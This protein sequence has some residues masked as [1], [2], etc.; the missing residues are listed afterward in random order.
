MYIVDI[1]DE[2]GTAVEDI[3]TFENVTVNN[4]P[5][6]PIIKTPLTNDIITFNKP[7]I[8]GIA[9]P[10]SNVNIYAD[11]VLDGNT[12]ADIDGNWSYNIN[13]SLSE[14]IP[15]VQTGI[16]IIQ[17]SFTD[18]SAP[19]S[20]ISITI[21]TSYS[22][23]E[24]ILYPRVQ[25][26]L[27]NNKPLLKG[28]AQKDTNIDISLDGVI[29][30]S[31]VADA[32]CKWEF[33]APL[34]PNGAH[35]LS[36]NAGI[37]TVNFNVDNAVAFPLITY[38]GS[39]LDGFLI[40]NNLPLIK[41]VALPGTPVTLWLNYIQY[42]T[43]GTVIADANGNWEFQVIP[44]TYPDPLSG[45]PIILAPIQN[46]VN[47]VS[48]SLVNHTV[49]IVVSGYKLN[50]PSYSSITGVVDNTVF[51]TLFSPK[52]MIEQ[53]N[54]LW[55]SI[56]KK[57]PLEF[58]Y[59]ETA[60]K[61]G[62]FR[63]VLGTKV[64]QENTDIPASSF[65]EPLLLLEEATI[66]TKTNQ[67]FAKALYNFNNGGV[68][69]ST[70]RGKDIFA[71]PIGSM[72]MSNIR[73][74]IQEWKLLLSPLTSY[75]TL[76]NLYRNGLIINLMKN[77]IY[78]SDYNSLHF[79]EYN[80]QLPE[81]FS[82]KEIYDDWFMNRNDAWADS[83]NYIQKFKKID[84]IRD[85]VITNG[86]SN[87]SL[88]MCRCRDGFPIH[89]YAYNPI[90][91]AP[92]SIPE[93]VLETP[94]IDFDEY[95]EDQY[96]FLLMCGDLICAVSERVETRRNWIIGKART[97]LIEANK[98]VNDV[99]FF[100]STGIR[101]I[102][103]VEG[104]IKKW[105][106]DINTIVAQ[107]ESG[108]TDI[109]WSQ[110]SR[111]RIVRYG[112]AKGLPDYLAMKIALAIVLDNLQIEGQDM[113]I[114]NDDKIIPSEDIEGVPLYYYNVSMTAKENTKGK[115]FAGD[116]DSDV[117]GAVLNIDGTAIGMPVGSLV[118]IELTNQ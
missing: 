20:T 18:L 112:T 37:D 94:D 2:L 89:T 111:K 47:V 70:Y 55:A 81:K 46:G 78:H 106:P 61:N 41:G 69:K 7:V 44:V 73:A 1:T 36:I 27:Y 83:P 45:L 109:V 63:T 14:Y 64:T 57:I 9:P 6:E 49:G 71:L 40:I 50:R 13:T 25:D 90:A 68:V 80:Y 52:N 79:V 107:E 67:T 24:Q 88:K 97:I 118:T 74:D 11:T 59:F 113:V 108:D 26:N 43:L 86:I 93:I 16:H 10:S 85:Q 96:F 101:T 117:S 31:V 28:I 54:P 82:F 77:T 115:V 39:E 48:T 60:D 92:I 23:V 99:G 5:L 65:G 91:P 75:T 98:S 3:E 58:M 34:I 87:L 29:I 76:L 84:V 100:Y 105:Q 116:P 15:G 95:P 12:T 33:Q 104:L 22:T 38:I 30:G 62:N 102:I 19:N 114:A 21:D 56:F 103:R 8:R 110:V 32:S 51:N 53:R 4:A 72:K 35:I 42:A 66:K 17:A